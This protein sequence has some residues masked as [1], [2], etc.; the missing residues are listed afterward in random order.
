MLNDHTI[1]QQLDR[2]VTPDGAP[3]LWRHPLLVF[4]AEHG[5]IFPSEQ[6][7]AESRVMKAGRAVTKSTSLAWYKPWM[8]GQLMVPALRQSPQYRV[9]FFSYE[10]V[11]YGGA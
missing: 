11:V 4:L 8:L 2:P 1:Q 6:A 9:E 7:A 10:T 3:I 5:R